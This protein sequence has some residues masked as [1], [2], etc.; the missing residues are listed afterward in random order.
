MPLHQPIFAVLVSL[1]VLLQGCSSMNSAM[2]GNTQKEAKAE[3]SWP[4]Q[5][6]GIQL[7]LIAANDINAFF[8]Q[9]HTVVL[10]VLQ[11]EDSKPFL[12]LLNDPKKLT[13]MLAD[14]DPGKDFLHL[15]RYI[16]SPGK[17]DI[18]DIDRVQDARYVAIVAGYYNFDPSG[19]ARLFR[20]PLNIKS[21]GMVSTTYTATPANLALR[22]YLGRQRI[23][24]AQSL[25][26]DADAA[27]NVESIPLDP[28]ET[29]IKLD[30]NTLR[31]GGSAGTR[32]LRQ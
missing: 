16:V 13:A 22:L 10:G 17:R 31:Q 26:F 5:R 11:M 27:P 3:V 19:A 28:Q 2:G 30:E 8:N 21:E 24:N 23:V 18:L 9:P 15:D 25:T 4:F 20:I 32:K 14:G 7:E 29:E 6:N 1:L 12:Q